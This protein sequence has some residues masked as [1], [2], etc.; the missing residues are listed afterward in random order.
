MKNYLKD[1]EK[2]L[3]KLKISDKEIQEIIN[4]HLEMLEEAKEDGVSDEDLVNKFGTPDSVAK[5]IYTDNFESKFNEEVESVVGSG[6]LEGYELFKTF[7]VTKDLKK[8]TVSLISEDFMFLPYE[9]ENIE[10]YAAKLKRPDEY[11]ISL[12]DDEFLLKRQGSKGIKLNIFG[13]QTT[14]D[15]GIRVPMGLV[16][17]E[18]NY[19]SVSGDGELD[20]VNATSISAKTTSGDFEASNLTAT[21]GIRL[22]AVSGDFEIKGLACDNLELSLVSGDLD[23]EQAAIKKEFKINTVSGDVD[24]KD[25]KCEHLDLRTVS[26]DFDGQ[27]VYPESVSL[28]SIS[29]DIEIANTNHDKEI[30]VI[31]K[32]T[33]SGD[34][35]I[36]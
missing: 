26:G 35:V 30:N 18:F 7:P 16:V 33:L 9:G 24:C 14:P 13:S 15:F 32:K 28:K 6:E 29:G 10:V 4:D 34:V 12:D 2:E 23:L 3:K 1:L 20:N 27:E 5:Q 19:N 25:V 21:E 36:R 11:E 8:F 31:S 17:E 22:T